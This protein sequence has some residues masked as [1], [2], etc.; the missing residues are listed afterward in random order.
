MIAEAGSAS[1]RVQS[2]LRQD[3]RKNIPLL[4]GL[5][6]LAI[7]T[8]AS[9]GAQVW[10]TELGAHG[11]LVLATGGWLLYHNNAGKIHPTARQSW[12]PASL[13]V[14][15]GLTFY[16]F[17]R[18]YDFISVEVGGLY[19]VFI[20][21]AW[22]LIGTP[23]LRRNVF[24]LFYLAFLIPLPGWFIDWITAPLQLLV[25]ATSLEI[26]QLAQLPVA[27]QGVALIVGPYQLLVEEA[28]SGMNSLVGMIA[29][30]LFYIFLLRRASWRY[31][32]LLTVLIVPVAIAVNV[33]RVTALI[34][35][36]YYFGDAAAQ[37]FLHGTT[38]IILFG[39][40][41]ML[42]F[43]ADTFLWHLLHR[44]AHK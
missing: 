29:V 12:F 39:T 25:S 17:G 19:F 42:I 32:A 36:T 43:A 23:G 44:K 41:L 9:L 16:I 31:A 14:I 13:L 8:L 15:A 22:R 34:G 27:R 37:G 35:I 2:W 18:A 7:P 3:W 38:G 1:P 26:S 33:M 11:P 24:P 6:V 5:M 21:F 10:T 20:A 28:C 30:S 40:G 4:L